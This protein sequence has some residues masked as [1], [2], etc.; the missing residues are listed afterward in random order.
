MSTVR[1]RWLHRYNVARLKAKQAQASV[2]YAKRVLKRHPPAPKSEFGIDW[3]WGTPNIPA[4]A[5]AGVK[6]AGRYLSG[7]T[8][9]NLTATQAHSLGAHGIDCIVVWETTANRAMAGRSAGIAD[10]QKAKV[11][12]DRCGMPSGKP[13]YFAVDFDGT[14]AQVKDY[15]AGVNTVLGVRRTGVYG[16]YRVVS[17]LFDAKM[18]AYGWQTYAWSGGKWDPRAQVQQY[19]NGHNLGGVACDYDR[20]THADFGQWRP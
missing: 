9:K 5:K 17:G 16:G 14:L 10:A 15:F 8:T 13:I 20:S 7:D 4:M 11:L 18:V 6:F 19:S 12:A 2:D 1:E 3:A